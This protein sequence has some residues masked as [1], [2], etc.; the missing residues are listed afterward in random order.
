MTRSCV[1]MF[2]PLIGGLATA[3]LLAGCAG[4]PQTE[5]VEKSLEQTSPERQTVASTAL[6]QIG[7]AYAPNM[8]GPDQYDDAGLAYYAYRQ[9]G[10][11]L[12]RTLADQLSAG[13]PISL[14]AAEPGDLV[15]FRLDTPDGKGRLTVGV[16]ASE[17]VA[18]VTLP[19]ATNAG[20]GVRRVSLAG[21]Y[22]R[23]RLIGVT[24]IL[25]DT[26]ND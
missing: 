10:R 4:A 18:V 7:D 17:S 24:R 25:A 11:S 16:L 23:A 22:W 19:G 1:C 14:D 21:D 20:G 8:A 15:F 5:S 2:K 13:V 6:A 9:N 26:G 3:L 12:P